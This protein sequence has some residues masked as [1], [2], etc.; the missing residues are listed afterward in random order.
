MKKAS[1][2][3]IGC[4]TNFADSGVLDATLR[5]LGIQMVPFGE[6]A[7]FVIVNS[8]VVTHRAEA[9]SR[10]ALSK[11]KRESPG[12]R[13]VLT[14]CGAHEAAIEN[15]SAHAD[16]VLTILQQSDEEALRSL[17]GID[18]VPR[19]GEGSENILRQ[20]RDRSRIFIKIQ[21]GCNNSCT[22]CIVPTVRGGSVSRHP[23]QIL[24]EIAACEN[25]GY[26][27]VVLTGNHI[28]NYNGGGKEGVSLFSLVESAIR[29]TRKVRLRLSSIEVDEVDDVLLEMLA[30][31]KRLCNHLHIPLQSGDDRILRK[32]G[33]WYSTDSYRN[34][35]EKIKSHSEMIC[36]GTD[37]ITGF[38]GETD[39][40][41]EK[42]F[43]FFQSL[44][45]DYAHIFPFSP[46]T[47]TKAKAMTDQVPERKKRERTAKLLREGAGKRKN[48]I[49]GFIGKTLEVV[50]EKVSPHNGS[51]Q[52][53]SD[54]YIKVVWRGS[55]RNHP[56]LVRVHIVGRDG[57][58]AVGTY[59]RGRD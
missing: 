33:R 13:T 36:I 15:I 12:T 43:R 42:T 17:L 4:K 24:D 3:T 55:T 35:L 47:G 1:I 51:V 29:S 32:M 9:D 39:E 38:P 2:K 22:Y 34:F 49:E 28:G 26:P 50:T 44:P 54:N 23:A 8:C 40:S 57:D 20:G 46:R 19:D 37:I 16:T 10:K 6:K 31:E 41:F 59:R 5:K 14:G 30:S 21:N 53:T 58:R 56:E 11:G 25:E 18:T 45:V 7:D 52:G 48:F 27:E